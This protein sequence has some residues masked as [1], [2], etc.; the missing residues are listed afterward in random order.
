MTVWQP[1]VE[2]VY[3]VVTMDDEP[4]NLTIKV[5]SVPVPSDNIPSS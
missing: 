3:T 2:Y 5:V 1:D 4:K